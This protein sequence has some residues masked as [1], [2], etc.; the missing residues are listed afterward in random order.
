MQRDRSCIVLESLY[1][2]PI[3]LPQYL[4]ING[5]VFLGSIVAIISEGIL[6]YLCRLCYNSFSTKKKLL[7]YNNMEDDIV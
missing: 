2:E 4:I 7:K 5:Q 1:I 6:F 3:E